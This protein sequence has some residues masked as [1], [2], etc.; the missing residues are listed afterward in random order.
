LTA[1][2]S[3]LLILF[4][5]AL[6]RVKTTFDSSFAILLGLAISFICGTRDGGFDYK[7]YQD[8]IYIIRT[9]LSVGESW[10]E[11]AQDAKDPIIAIVVTMADFF[12]EDDNLFFIF[13]AILGFLPKVLLALALPKNKTIFLASYIVLLSPGLEFAAI[14]SA[15]GIGFLGLA[16]ITAYAFWF[17]VVLFLLAVASHISMVAGGVLLFK[18]F[19]R[20]SSSNYWYAPVA[21]II[22]MLLI[23]KFMPDSMQ[24][25]AVSPGTI[26]APLFPFISLCGLFVFT[27]QRF[28]FFSIT[29]CNMFR[30]G[31]AAAI[32]FSAL[33]MAMAIPIAVTSTRLLE[34]SLYFSLF[35]IILA[36]SRNKLNIV[37]WLSVVLLFSVIG[38]LNITR[39]TWL[40]VLKEMSNS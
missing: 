25:R 37:S 31:I 3:I 18:R 22:I 21:S 13:M 35:A 15:V 24:D 19:W 11:M 14:R 30:A 7:Q 17:R 2:I 1:F 32:F 40:V 20:I 38:Y 8:M 34:V 39:H 6:S 23:I 9:S 27:R 4:A 36:V 29:E 33:A 26:F 5:V 16:V 10:F 12:S 28:I